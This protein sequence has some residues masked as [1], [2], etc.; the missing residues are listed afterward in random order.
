MKVECLKSVKE[1]EKGKKKRFWDWKENELHT[2]YILNEI[3]LSPFLFYLYFLVV[4]NANNVEH[5]KLLMILAA[6]YWFLINWLLIP[7][8]QKRTY[9]W[10]K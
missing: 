6:Q 10:Y 8:K 2:N 1:M 3:I 7:L 9:A 4:V 5:W